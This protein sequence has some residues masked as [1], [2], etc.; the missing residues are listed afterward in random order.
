MPFAVPMV[1]R[2]PRDHVIDCSYF[3]LTEATGFS[4]KNKNHINYPNLPSAMRPVLQSDDLKVPVPPE[5]WTIDED[6]TE[7][8]DDSLLHEVEQESDDDFLHSL[9]VLIS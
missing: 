1:W 6:D 9:T 7:C 5:A 8:L 2:E 3:C 4:A